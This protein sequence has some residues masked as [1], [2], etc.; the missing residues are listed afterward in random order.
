MSDAFTIDRA[1]TDQRLLGAAMGDQQSWSVWLA[2]LKAAFGLKL[3]DDELA[4]FASVA[5]TRSPPTKRVR[6]LWCVAGRRSGKSRMAAALGVYYACFVKHRLAPGERGMVLILAASQAQARTVFEYVRG[7]LDTSS[8]LSEEIASS[9]QHEIVLRNGITVA[10]HSNSFRTVRGRTL[11]AVIMDEIAFWRDEAS[12][13]PDIETYTA[14]LPSLATTG[15]MMIA[16]STPYRKIGL[17]HQKHRDHFGVDSADTLVVS[18]A[19]KLLNPTLDDAVIAATTA[20]DPS[21]APA[22]W[23]AEFRDDISAFLPDELID[24][25]I[26][27]GR[28]LELPPVGENYCAFCDASGGVGRDSYTICVGHRDA[29]GALI[30]DVVR[31]TTGKFEPA[32]VTKQYAELLREY[33][34]GSVTGDNYAALW[35]S[36]TW[37]DVGIRYTRSELPKSQIYLECVPLFTRGLVRLPDHAR[38]LREFRLLELHQHRGGR[39][40][41]DH[42]RG[43]H[44]DHANAVC[45]VLRELSNSL[46]YDTSMAWVSGPDTDVAAKVPAIPKRLC[47]TMSNA[48][49]ERI[50]A[51]VRLYPGPGVRT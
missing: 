18:A 21:A 45:G 29:K 51:P 35:V 16:I 24:S 31:G 6:E 11:C 40:S 9:T 19:S 41:V 48:E 49:Y 39:Q 33:K 15:G 47:P 50:S 1:L 34:I 43:G 23:L 22:E 44:D 5:G 3:S 8:V 27:Y 36:G 28:P 12:A 32:E 4:T 2:V 30:I 14:V 26:E 25:A 7:F 20:A 13:L 37:G 42:P 46:G 38:L 17:L 10:V